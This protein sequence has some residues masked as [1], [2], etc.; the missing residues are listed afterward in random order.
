MNR[1]SSPYY[2]V[3]DK[4]LLIENPWDF[5]EKFDEYKRIQQE[6]LLLNA[7]LKIKYENFK[8]LLDNDIQIMD[9]LYLESDNNHKD[10]F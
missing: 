9:E 1:S 5:F 3:V 4:F 7:D 8:K 2:Q 6:A 10:L